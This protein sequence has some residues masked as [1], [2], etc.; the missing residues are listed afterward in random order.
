[1]SE[2]PSLLPRQP[3]PR[4]TNR[5]RRGSIGQSSDGLADKSKDEA[6]W[7]IID[8]SK[9]SENRC[10]LRDFAA[11]TST[12]SE[13]QFTQSYPYWFLIQENGLSQSGA[14]AF[15]T[16]Q[17]VSKPQSDNYDFLSCPVFL[18]RKAKNSTFQ[19]MITVGRAENNDLVIGYSQVSKFHAYFTPCE[20]S[21]L[22]TDSRST[23]GTFVNDERIEPSQSIELRV[24]SRVAFGPRLSFRLLNPK[25]MFGYLKFARSHTQQ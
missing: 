5:I 13:E 11:Q 21:I 9:A 15:F 18:I 23:N 12:F 24:N 10:R 20:G 22:V 17:D 25:R 1:M 14:Y 8:M 4:D 16:S 6:Q 7:P 19:E 3:D 2:Y